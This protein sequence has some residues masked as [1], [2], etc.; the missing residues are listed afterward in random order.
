MWFIEYTTPSGS[1]VWIPCEESKE[2]LKHFKCR[3]DEKGVAA[4]A[5][6]VLQNLGIKYGGVRICFLNTIEIRPS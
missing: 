1:Q 3:G 5:E 6:K 4:I 2:I